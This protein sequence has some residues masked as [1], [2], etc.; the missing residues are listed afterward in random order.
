MRPFYEFSTASSLAHQVTMSMFSP[1]LILPSVPVIKTFYEEVVYNVSAPKCEPLKL[2]LV[3]EEINCSTA[4]V[5][6][7]FNPAMFALCLRC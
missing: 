7:V 3:S 6:D 1:S 4:V 2:H 5:L